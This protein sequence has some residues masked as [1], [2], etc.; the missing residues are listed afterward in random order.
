MAF[1][2]PRLKP[3]V[4]EKLIRPALAK[5]IDGSCVKASGQ[6]GKSFKSWFR[7]AAISAKDEVLATQGTM[8]QRN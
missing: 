5:A 1:I 8:T 4:S 7:H 2:N 6:S 3:W